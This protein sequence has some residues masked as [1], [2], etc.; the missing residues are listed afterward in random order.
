MVEDDGIEPTTSCLQS[1]RTPNCAN[2]PYLEWRVRFELTAL[3]VCNQFPWASRASPHDI[4]LVL[5]CLFANKGAS[6]GERLAVI[7][8][9]VPRTVGPA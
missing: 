9:S 3:L 6:S 5:S 4:S 7:L 2:P 8:G 1:R